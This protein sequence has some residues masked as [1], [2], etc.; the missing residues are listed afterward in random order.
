MIFE[1]PALPKHTAPDKHYAGK[2]T[3]QRMSERHA[4]QFVTFGGLKG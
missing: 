4:S 3:Q 1:K 2:A